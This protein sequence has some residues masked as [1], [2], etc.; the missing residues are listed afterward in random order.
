[1]LGATATTRM[2]R[3]PP[4]SPAIIQ[5]RRIPSGEDVRSLILPKSGLPTRDRRPPTPATSAR[6]P[7]AWSTPTSDLTLRARVT[8][9]GAI[10]I[11][12]MLM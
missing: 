4:A 2:P 8:S 6:L 7:G 11:R 12:A 10:S 3:Q 1:M 5:G 9:S